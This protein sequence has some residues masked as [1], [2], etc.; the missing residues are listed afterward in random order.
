MFVISDDL[1]CRAG[2]EVGQGRATP[3][4][5]ED[6]CGEAASSPLSAN[7]LQ[8]L[9]GRSAHGGRDRFSGGRG[10]LA[11]EFTPPGP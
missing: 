9:L 8:A 1:V 3:P 4:D 5:L 2:I 6:F 10:Q 7:P 11:D